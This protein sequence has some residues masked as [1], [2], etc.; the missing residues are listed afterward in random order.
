MM[1]ILCVEYVSVNVFVDV[2]AYVF[3]TQDSTHLVEGQVL[4][5]AFQQQS[6]EFKFRL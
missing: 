5:F 1:K 6:V 2:Y 3:N 4:K